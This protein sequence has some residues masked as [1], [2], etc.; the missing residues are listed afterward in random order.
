MEARAA[1]VVLAP[2]SFRGSTA[3]EGLVRESARRA[4][5]TAAR[6]LEGSDR[7]MAGS[8]AALPDRGLVEAELTES[9]ELT[10]VELYGR[11]GTGHGLV[12]E[13][14][15]VGGLTPWV[16]WATVWLAQTQETVLGRVRGLAGSWATA[17]GQGLLEAMS[18]PIIPAE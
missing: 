11:F 2:R 10:R 13:L 6:L 17:E 4:R 7:W 16:P 14:T 18:L 9:R 12:V 5:L 3:P 8:Q 15:S 1:W